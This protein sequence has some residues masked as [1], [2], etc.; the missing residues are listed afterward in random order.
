MPSTRPSYPAP[1]SGFIL[2]PS[3]ACWAFGLL[4]FMGA[5]GAASS[6]EL[7]RGMMFTAAGTLMVIFPPRVNLPKW[8]WALVAVFLIA[9]AT[10]FLPVKQMPGWRQNLE[11]LG[12]DTGGHIVIQVRRAAEIHA[13]YVSMF[14]IGL[15][16][17]LQR[18]TAKT[19]AH[20]ALFFTL[21]V[22]IYAILAQ[23][24]RGQITVN[25]MGSDHYGFLPNRNHTGTYLAMGGVCGLGATLQALREKR[26]GRLGI[27]LFATL[28][29]LWAVFAWSISRGGVL[30]TLLGGLLWLILMGPR[31]LGKHG[32]R[33]LVLGSILIIG[34]FFVVETKA[35]SR[36]SETAEKVTVIETSPTISNPPPKSKQESNLENLDFRIPT[37]LDT[38]DM[39]RDTPWT[40]VGAGQYEFIFPQYRNRTSIANDSANVHPESDWLWLAAEWGLPATIT[41]G[42]LIF[43]AAIHSTLKLQEGRNRTQRSA[44]LVAACLL[45]L[46][47]IFDVPAHAISLS[48]AAAFLYMLSL[49]TPQTIHSSKLLPWLSRTA[50]AVT[51][52]CG[53]FF[54]H[55]HFTQQPSA[56]LLADN[57]LKKASALYEEDQEFF[58]TRTDPTHIP[59][60][61]EDKLAPALLMVNEALASSPLEARLWYMKAIIQF[62]YVDM[63]AD[64]RKAFAI[65]RTLDPTWIYPLI[66]QARSWAAT[67]PE[68]ASVLWR[69]AFN[70][71]YKIEKKF[72]NSPYTQAHTLR[73]IQFS[74][75]NPQLRKMAESLKLND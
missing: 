7:Y 8:W 29:I 21:G 4:I 16:M 11:S 74:I 6:W 28:I 3:L 15:W 45:P 52:G 27:A 56:N 2:N 61:S 54:L 26:F 55:C 35:K 32:I 70:R 47:G 14:L 50:G 1:T 67:N 17:T 42:I 10:N 57:H 33:A 43:A 75:S 12:L 66:Q 13:I 73:R 51:L 48:C 38:W 65:Q 23:V 20:A 36:I 5:L 25:D 44:C 72:P 9:G 30:L 49:P 59:S 18:T 19:R 37:A 62:G 41:L 58:K 46:H 63:Q 71:A 31:H 39:I 34:A 68:E 22:A 24:L 69:E 60:E 40:G 53:I 64:I